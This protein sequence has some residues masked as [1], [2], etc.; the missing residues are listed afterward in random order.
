[1]IFNWLM[2]PTLIAAWLLFAAG[3]ASIRRC[4]TPTHA[5]SLLGVWFVLGIPGFLL[6]LYYL[7]GFDDAI[8]FY[9]YRS[10]PAVE[11][12][13][14]GAGLFAGGLAELVKR[15]RLL[16]RAMLIAVLSVGIVIPYLKPLLAPLPSH[17]FTDQWQDDV[18]LQ[19]TS[20]SC[21]AASAATVLKAL[22]QHVTEQSLAHECFT[23]AGGTENWY[24]ARAFR[25]R[26]YRV[27]YRIETGYPADLHLPAIAGVRVGGIGH[28]IALVT[29]S[30][31]M[32]VTG[33]PLVGRNEVPVG[34]IASEFDYTGFFMEIA[35]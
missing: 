35:P 4:Q 32:V 33:D 24:L 14:A 6:P 3:Q 7:H 15:P 13:A 19:S 23:Y 25:R 17:S 18:C 21:G 2:I 10:L 31:Q 22:G 8:L 34:E 29:N 27:T 16:V 9:Q 5:I 1:M 11:L 20:S 30:P 26:G 28:F 12:T